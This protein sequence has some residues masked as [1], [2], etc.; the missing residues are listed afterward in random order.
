[1]NLIEESNIRLKQYNRRRRMERIG[2]EIRK[3]KEEY[4]ALL[5]KDMKN[6]Y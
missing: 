6:G 3:L 2:S 1:M 5:K 4:K